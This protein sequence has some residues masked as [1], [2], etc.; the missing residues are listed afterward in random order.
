MVE[1]YG[2]MGAFRKEIGPNLY[3]KCNWRKGYENIRS[4]RKNIF[5]IKCSESNE[6]LRMINIYNSILY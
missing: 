1:F 2:K 4:G 6:H 5:K 3:K